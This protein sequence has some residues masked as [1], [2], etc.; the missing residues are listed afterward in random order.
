MENVH[1]DMVALLRVSVTK[2]LGHVA[3]AV[4]TLLHGL[5]VRITS[6]LENSARHRLRQW[7]PVFPGC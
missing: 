6:L 7:H 2:A 4:W 5:D 1:G 3:L